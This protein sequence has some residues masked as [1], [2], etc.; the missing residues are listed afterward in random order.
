MRLDTWA[1]W[2]GLQPADGAASSCVNAWRDRA[3]WVVSGILMPTM[4]DGMPMQ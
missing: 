1:F 4:L 2:A 3:C